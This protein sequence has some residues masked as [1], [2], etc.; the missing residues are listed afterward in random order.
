[1]AIREAWAL[2]RAHRRTVALDELGGPN[3][4]EP[5]F[6][7][8]SGEGLQDALEARRALRALAG[9]PERQRHYLTQLAAGYSYQEIAQ[10]EG[11]ASTTS[12]STSCAPA[13]PCASRTPPERHRDGPAQA[14]RDRER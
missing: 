4:E 14:P 10:A 13:K 5:A 8:D 6:L 9:L 12:T 3:G 7:A 1:M 11:A 2:S